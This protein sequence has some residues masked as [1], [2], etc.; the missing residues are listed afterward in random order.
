MAKNRYK[1]IECGKILRHIQTNQWMCDQSP[2]VC[3]N[4]IKV[5]YLEEE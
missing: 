1:C 4:S 2:S 5:V 3:M